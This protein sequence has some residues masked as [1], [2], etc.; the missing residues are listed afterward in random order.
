MIEQETMSNEDTPLSKE[1]G[2]EQLKL[3]LN[4]KAFKQGQVILCVDLVS[5]QLC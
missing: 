5:L 1:E 2:R 4:S 3:L